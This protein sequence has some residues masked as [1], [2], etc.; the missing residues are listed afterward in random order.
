MVKCIHVDG[1]SSLAPHSDLKLMKSP[2]FEI[3][4]MV[5]RWTHALFPDGLSLWGWKC[6]P[7]IFEIE[8]GRFDPLDSNF[9]NCLIERDFEMVR[10][11]DYPEMPS[12]L[13]CIF[14]VAALGD[15]FRDWPMLLKDAVSFYEVFC[16]DSYSMD[17]AF[18]SGYSAATE[19][20]LTDSTPGIENIY[21]YWKCEKASSPR[22][23]IL[24]P[25]RQGVH[26]GSNLTIRY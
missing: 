10:R 20:R 14:A 16:N 23:E 24:L 19:Y 26:I 11:R 5:L 15:L 17:A 1:N 8:N 2:P 22:V 12:R 7:Y 4:G 25:L 21:K 3:S 18:L 9:C 13:Q 6:I